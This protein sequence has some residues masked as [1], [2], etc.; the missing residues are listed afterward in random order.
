MNEIILKEA[1]LMVL[2]TEEE[3]AALRAKYGGRRAGRKIVVLALS[4]DCPLI[5]QPGSVFSK[6]KDFALSLGYTDGG[7]VIGQYLKKSNGAP[8]TVRGVTFQYLTDY[9]NGNP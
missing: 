9:Q 7:N 1:T 3:I 6:V 2:P 8:A 5:L 4:A